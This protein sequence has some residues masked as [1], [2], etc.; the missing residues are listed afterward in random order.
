MNKVQ[1][2]LDSL[3]VETI[4]SENLVK[5]ADGSGLSSFLNVVENYVKSKITP[6]HE[7]AGVF[8]LLAP[9]IL[10]ALGFP[11]LATFLKVAEMF[12]FDPA[13]IFT[14]IAEKV[15]EIL[16]SGAKEI[17][18]EHLDGIIEST[19]QAN[20]GSN[21][22]EEDL[23]KLQSQS[24]S[25]R[26]AQILKLAIDEISLDDLNNRHLP[27]AKRAGVIS[28]LARLIGMKP[29]AASVLGKIIGWI[30]KVILISG[31]FMVGGDLLNKMV[32]RKDVPPTPNGLPTLSPSAPAQN[33][34]LPISHQSLFKVNPGYTEEGLN[35][36]NGWIEAVPPSQIGP[37]IAEWAQDIYPDLK[38]KGNFIQSSPIFQKIVEVIQEYN[39]N[40][41]S[42]ITFMPRIFTSRK[43]VVD[44]FID[45]L[46][47][48]VEHLNMPSPIPNAEP[49]K[50]PAPNA[51]PNA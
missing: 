22:T 11:L 27:L 39:S 33:I 17:S 42:K 9:G 34:S 10:G 18:P 28:G 24:L 32:G 19:V 12:G 37:Q 5:Q 36:S 48:K 38:G 26:D 41:N 45:D 46:A 40:N 3:I 21:P 47:N 43:K 35:K 20:Y 16:M 4:L 13:K 30:I 1:F 2:Y 44:T 14:E 25:L 8:D 49:A 7:L 15:K 23:K 31:G 50:K 51:T 6:G 29:K